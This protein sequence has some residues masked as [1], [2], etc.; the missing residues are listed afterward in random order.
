MLFVADG[1]TRI[2]MALLNSTD[3]LHQVVTIAGTGRWPLPCL[4]CR[5]PPLAPSFAA[6]LTHWRVIQARFP[7][8]AGRGGTIRVTSCA[9]NV[10]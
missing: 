2:R 4:S 1:K 6:L 5:A 7:R 10:C 3:E 9:H 8:W